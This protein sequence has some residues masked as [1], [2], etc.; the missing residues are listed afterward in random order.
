METRFIIFD[1]ARCQI[2]SYADEDDVHDLFYLLKKRLIGVEGVSFARI[3]EYAASV[4]RHKLAVNLVCL[5]T[6][7]RRQIPLLL[8]LEQYREAL[9][10]ALEGGDSDM[11][12]AVMSSIRN[13]VDTPVFY[14]YLRSRPAAW[15]LF[16]S[17]FLGNDL[18]EDFI[19]AHE[20]TNDSYGLALFNLEES[21]WKRA[22]KLVFDEQRQS[23]KLHA[24]IKRFESVRAYVPDAALFAKATSELSLLQK[25][26]LRLENEANSSLSFVGLSVLQTFRK[27]LIHGMEKLAAKIKGEF[28]VPEMTAGLIRLEVLAETRDWSR[29]IGAVKDRRFQIPLIRV[30]S[31]LH[32]KEAPPDVIHA[33]ALRASSLL[34]RILIYCTCSMDDRAIQLIEA[35]KERSDLVFLAQLKAKLPASSP[36]HVHLGL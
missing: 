22:E 32:E 7:V 18:G 12:L 3:A 29:V 1:W 11:T 35:S 28:R 5:E 17:S 36:L 21:T 24:T 31:R 23:E 27:C 26:Q 9:D 2:I 13:K 33:L 34:D 4:G 30:A 25:Y 14:S 16:R 10:R 15:T 8:S 19:S 20:F 6:D